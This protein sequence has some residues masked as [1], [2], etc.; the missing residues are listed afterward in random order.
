ME[1]QHYFPNP[2]QQSND[3]ASFLNNLL[4][5]MGQIPNQQFYNSKVGVQEN[6]YSKSDENTSQTDTQSCSSHNQESNSSHTYKRKCLFGLKC[7][8]LPFG[9][10]QFYHPTSSQQDQRSKTENEKCDY[11]IACNDKECKLTK[12]HPD[13][14]KGY[15]SCSDIECELELVNVPCIFDQKC[16]RDDCVFVHSTKSKRSPQKEMI[17]RMKDQGIKPS[18]E[19]IDLF[20]IQEEDKTKEK[21][22]YRFTQRMKSKLAIQ[23]YL[24]EL[25]RLYTREIIYFDYQKTDEITVEYNITMSTWK[26]AEKQVQD[27][28]LHKLQLIVIDASLTQVRD[29]CDLFRKVMKKK[30]EQIGIIDF[31]FDHHIDQ[32][33]KSNLSKK[34]DRHTISIFGFRKDSEK[35]VKLRSCLESF[36]LSTFKVGNKQDYEE[37]ENDF[38]Y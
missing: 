2:F 7:R 3:Q 14:Q 35:L 30:I 5:C 28:L 27:Y 15:D 18:Q 38:M 31:W 20:K 10:C 29:R 23:K 22:V 33:S 36:L 6:K 19:N 24:H 21:I 16:L 37:L 9:T 12:E 34:N 26:Y 8:N 32:F 17:E 25:K 4:Y 13:S 1:R 11:G